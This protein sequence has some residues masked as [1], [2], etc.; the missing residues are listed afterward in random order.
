MSRVKAKQE[1]I[2]F[3]SSLENPASPLD[4]APA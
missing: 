2:L 3:S 1:Y 4:T